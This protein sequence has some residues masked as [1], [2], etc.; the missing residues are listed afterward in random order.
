MA[1]QVESRKHVTLNVLHST[2]FIL[3][4]LLCGAKGCPLPMIKSVSILL[5][6]VSGKKEPLLIEF[7]V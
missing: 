2:T 5:Y 7:L 1:K 3:L 4:S 6:R